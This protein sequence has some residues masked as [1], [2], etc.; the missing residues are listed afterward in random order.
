[1]QYEYSFLS[2]RT[3]A[4]DYSIR[5][6]MYLIGMVL[7]I[8]QGGQ[9]TFA[10]AFEVVVQHLANLAFSHLP[11]GGMDVHAFRLDG[12]RQGFASNGLLCRT[13]A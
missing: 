12:R 3:Q 1:M 5:C 6:L 13:K 2:F 4:S 10:N 11:T 9:G 7:L 8:G